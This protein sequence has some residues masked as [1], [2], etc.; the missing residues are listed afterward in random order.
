MIKS[1]LLFLF[2]LAFCM[3]LLGQQ[4]YHYNLTAS[5]GLACNEVYQIL[6]DKK[7]F[8]WLGTDKGLYKYDGHQF[9]KFINKEQNGIGV[10]YLYEDKRGRIW[11][12][13]FTGQIFYTKEDGLELFANWYDNAQDFARMVLDTVNQRLW[14]NGNSELH[15]FNIDL[16]TIPAN[17]KDIEIDLEAEM[18]CPHRAYFSDSK[19]EVW[20]KSCYVSRGKIVDNKMQILD[21]ITSDQRNGPFNIHMFENERGVHSIFQPRDTDVNHMWFYEG[22]TIQEVQLPDELYSTRI[23]MTRALGDGRIAICTHSGLVI[24]D[25]DLNIQGPILLPN[26]HVS[27][28]MLDR[29]GTLWITTLQNGLFAVPNEEVIIYNRVNC[30]IPFD[31]IVSLASDAQNRVYVGSYSGTLARMDQEEEFELFHKIEGTFSVEALRYDKFRDKIVASNLG[32]LEFDPHNIHSPPKIYGRWN[33]KNIKD[34]AAIDEDFFTVGSGLEYHLT[35]MKALAQS[36]SIEFPYE[37]TRTKMTEKYFDEDSRPSTFDIGYLGQS[38]I[39]SLSYSP[40]LHQLWASTR[41]GVFMHDNEGRHVIM[42]SDAPL[43]CVDIESNDKGEVYLS[44]VMGQIFKGNESG[45]DLFHD[46]SSDQPVVAPSIACNDTLLVAAS[47]NSLVFVDLR[48]GEASSFDHIDGLPPSDITEIIIVENKVF[49]AT[50]A[51]L[52]SIPLDVRHSND[53]APFIEI[54]AIESAGNLLPLDGENILEYANNQLK[55]QLEGASLRSQGRFVFKYRLA[56]LE[57]EWNTNSSD[58]SQVHYPSIPPGEYTFE[59]MTLNEDGVSSVVGSFPLLVSKPYWGAWWFI[60]IVGILFLAFAA[61]IS[62]IIIRSRDKKA[63]LIYKLKGSEI[64]ALKAQMNPHF[65]FNSLNSI[66]GLVLKRDLRTSNNYLGKF[67]DLMRSTLSASG[68]EWITVEEEIYMLKLYLELEKLRF[69]KDLTVNFEHSDLDDEADQLLIP[70]MII[71][72]YVENAIKHGL[73]HKEGDKR[74]DI[75]FTLQHDR[76]SCV[77]EDNG[78]GRK[79]AIAIGA[80]KKHNSFSGMAN[81]RRISLMNELYGNH[82]DFSISDRIANGQAAGTVVSF[83]YPIKYQF[84][85]NGN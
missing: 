11:C 35:P 33:S 77:I 45:V 72:P 49:A 51:G 59:A 19:G 64:T 4:P 53:V 28:A 30:D 41:N 29:E 5:H 80:G 12:S 42:K 84:E 52:L 20:F 37:V 68:K 69:S 10:T 63:K 46:L 78:I 66:Q 43:H 14:F 34:Y 83:S 27:D 48:T 38:R 17:I 61:G 13:N 36:P 15:G 2:S 56:G 32:L 39:N 76:V 71:Q 75:R 23:Y 55:V 54:K 70:A 58:Q 21:G 40:P 44:G 57:Q 47:D 7:G 9:K 18:E 74:L 8:L 22:D 25:Q 50:S 1:T 81:E 62:W 31:E 65:I 85:S 82:I 67:S 60:V 3:T 26:Q 24:L 79:A 73:M 6:Q 16:D